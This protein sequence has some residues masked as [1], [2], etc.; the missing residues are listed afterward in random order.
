MIKGIVKL[1]VIVSQLRYRLA[2]TNIFKINLTMNEIEKLKELYHKTL[3]KKDKAYIEGLCATYYVKLN[4]NCS[5]C[6][7]D[8]ILILIK[9]ITEENLPK[10]E[11]ATDSRKYILKSGVD[12]WFGSIRVNAVTLTDELAEKIIAKGFPVRYFEK[13]EK[14]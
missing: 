14:Q 7:S 9:K 13:Y 5:S 12:V 8:A 6:Y 11:T 3:S 1:P 2:V 4:K 10:K